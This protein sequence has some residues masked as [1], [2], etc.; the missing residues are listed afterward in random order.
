M[1]QAASQA[2]LSEVPNPKLINTTA[3]ISEIL[4]LMGFKDFD[5]LQN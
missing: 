4:I 3:K 5:M 2:A 1:F